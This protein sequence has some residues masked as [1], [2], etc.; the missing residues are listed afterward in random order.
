M[1]SPS[2]RQSY[3]EARAER[4]ART[5]T[6]TQRPYV[7]PRVTQL[8]DEGWYPAQIAMMLKIPVTEVRLMLA[9]RRK[10]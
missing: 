1:P 2:S 7:D 8:A 5:F 3:A 4:H 10:A 9:V 6:R